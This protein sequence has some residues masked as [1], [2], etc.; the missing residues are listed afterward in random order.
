MHVVHKIKQRS[1]EFCFQRR[2]RNPTA[3]LLEKS[4]DV[5]TIDISSVGGA[6]SGGDSRVCAEVPSG[7]VQRLSPVTRH[8]LPDI[9]A[10][11][12]QC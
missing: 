9:P 3:A 11:S 6:G 7:S 5:N 10:A 2:N 1:G 12:F 8:Y 4:Q